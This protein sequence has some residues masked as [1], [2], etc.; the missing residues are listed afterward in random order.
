MQKFHRNLLF[1]SSL[2]LS[3]LL[4]VVTTYAQSSDSSAEDAIGG[5]IFLI[6][7]CIGI[8]SFGVAAYVSYWIYQDANKKGVD[9]AMLWAILNFFFF[10]IIFIVYYLAIRPK[11]STTNNEA[12]QTPDNT[13]QPPMTK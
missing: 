10:P 1:T 12:I 4:F 2:L 9:N 7:C 8:V 11:Q 6:S 3:N 13:P 5:F